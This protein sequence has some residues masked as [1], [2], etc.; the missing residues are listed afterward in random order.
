MKEAERKRIYLIFFD[1]PNSGKRHNVEMA[2]N[3][4]IT[5]LD[6]DNKAIKSLIF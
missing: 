1:H 5:V 4:L 2:N 3:E 6:R